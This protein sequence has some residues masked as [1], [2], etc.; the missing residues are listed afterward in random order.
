MYVA[1]RRVLF[2]RKSRVGLSIAAILLLLAAG[3]WNRVLEHGLAFQWTKY[4]SGICVGERCSWMHR[5][6][7]SHGS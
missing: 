3:S 1:D 7:A 2:W 5:A 6:S 4:L